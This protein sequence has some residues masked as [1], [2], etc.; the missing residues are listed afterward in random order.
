MA[1]LQHSMIQLQDHYSFTPEEMFYEVSYE[2]VTLDVSTDLEKIDTPLGRCFTFNGPNAIAKQG[3]RVA[4]TE[5]RDSGLR[6]YLRLHQD[7]YFII[8]DVT[9]GFRARSLMVC[10]KLESWTEWSSYF[11]VNLQAIGRYNYS[12]VNPPIP[13]P[14]QPASPPPSTPPFFSP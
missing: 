5:G 4:T 8:E 1:A 3:Q 6:A 7:Q 12:F 13:T 9:A 2:G 11:S 14:P 10:L